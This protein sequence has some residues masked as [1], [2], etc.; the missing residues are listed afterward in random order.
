[1]KMKIHPHLSSPSPSFHPLSLSHLEYI[2]FT[3]FTCNPPWH[4][5]RLTLADRVFDTNPPLAFSS[6]FSRDRTKQ[7]PYP[8]L[9]KSPRYRKKYMKKQ[10]KREKRDEMKSLVTPKTNLN[11]SYCCLPLTCHMVS[12]YFNFSF[13]YPSFR[14]SFLVFH[15][16]KILFSMPPG[17]SASNFTSFF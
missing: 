12:T 8:F 13:L 1:M 15:G 11:F 10:A 16:K 9:K 5:S 6:R 4:D 14:L 17:K 2:L 7:F 3:A